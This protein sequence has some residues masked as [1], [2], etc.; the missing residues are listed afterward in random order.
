MYNAWLHVF[1]NIIS[2]LSHCF[3]RKGSQML[4]WFIYFDSGGLECL[5]A[6]RGFIWVVFC[7]KCSALVKYV[8]A[9]SVLDSCFPMSLV[10]LWYSCSILSHKALRLV[11]VLVFAS[12]LPLST[13]R[14]TRPGF[15]FPVFFVT[16]PLEIYLFILLFKMDFQHLS[17]WWL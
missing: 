2:M 13:V 4:V 14:Y 16:S 1:F 7:L 15:L 17:P 5:H 9:L 3:M 8:S 10:I 11:S 6:Q 12:I